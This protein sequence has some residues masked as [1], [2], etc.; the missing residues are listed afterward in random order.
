MIR[1]FILLAITA[2]LCS[3]ASKVVVKNCEHKGENI[4][5]CEEL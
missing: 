1:L 2:L 5:E 3:C 4:F